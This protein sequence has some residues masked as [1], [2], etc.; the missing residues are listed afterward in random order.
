MDLKDDHL[1]ALAFLH[2]AQARIAQG[3][4][5]EAR[6]AS[7]RA[8]ALF[9]RQGDERA[10]ALA[11]SQL[12]GIR[13][14]MGEYATA[15]EALESE[16]ESLRPA[17]GVGL[18]GPR[19]WALALQCRF[20][21]AVRL[22]EIAAAERLAEADTRGLATVLLRLQWAHRSR[23]EHIRALEVSTEAC[24]CF[25]EAGDRLGLARASLSL[26]QTLVAQGLTG[27]GVDKLRRAAAELRELGDVHCEAEALWLAGQGLVELGRL[28]EARPLLEI[29]LATVREVPDRDDEFRIEIDLARLLRAEGRPQ[30][31]LATA[32]SAQA[33]ATD[34]GSRDGAAWA[35]VEAAFAHLA[36]KAGSE[37]LTVAEEAVDQL[38]RIGSG[39][40]WRGLWALGLSQETWSQQLAIATL[41]R[42]E[43]LLDAARA[44]LAPAD[45]R[46]LEEV[47]R[48]PLADLH[49]LL[50]ATGDAGR[51]AE[52]RRRW[53]VAL[54]AD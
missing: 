12:A 42:C 5:A 48:A 40:L 54:M 31:A 29:A 34:L 11:R 43:K 27:K 13:I 26:G 52:L 36:L 44:P 21:E 6:A 15:A 51:A 19:G 50:I 22:L 2:L 23:G 9:A 47:R 37:A 33:I 46:T 28:D 53:P 45:R 1:L 8:L 16:D 39:E 7:E 20:A 14:A 41:E 3:R 18:A 49:R 38:A 10:A 30:E 35:L 4:Q 24:A 25:R 32:R 17:L